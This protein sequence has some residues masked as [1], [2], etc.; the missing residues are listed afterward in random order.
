MRGDTEARCR[1]A[2]DNQ[3]QLEAI[4][5]LI[6]RNVGEFGTL[7]HFCEQARRPRGE[8]VWIGIF[9][10]VLILRAAHARIDGQILHRLQINR[11]ARDQL[12]LWLQ[13]RDDLAD[14]GGADV[15]RF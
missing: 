1:I 10:R 2:I 7:A 15:V 12:Q 9:N 11:D 14:A 13:A 8:F 5:L 4:G 6:G 3:M